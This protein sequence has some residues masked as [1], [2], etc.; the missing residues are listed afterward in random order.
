MQPLT[1]ENSFIILTPKT[2]LENQLLLIERAGRTCYQSETSEISL[3]TAKKFVAMIL[4]LGHESVIEHSHLTVQFNNVSRGFTHE[5]VRHRL[6][7]FSQESTRYVDYAKPG[8]GPDLDKFQLKCLI[9][10]H[11]DDQAKVKLDDGREMSFLEMIEEIEKFYRALRKSGWQPQ[12]ARQILPQALKA[13]IVCTTNFRQWRHIF[14]MRLSK[15]AHWEI[16]KV[17]GDLLLELQKTIP[18]VFDDFIHI[19]VDQNGLAYFGNRA[20]II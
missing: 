12:D 11:Q 16:R 7:A 8:Q 20:S 10:P 15:A 14:E 5:L 9:P 6:C 18:V 4:K 2:E 17:M 19:G 1:N 3:E 13:Q